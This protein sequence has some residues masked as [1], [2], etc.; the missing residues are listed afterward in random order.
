MGY[1]VNQ[2]DKETIPNISLEA[3]N[4]PMSSV[5]KKIEQASHYKIIF[6]YDEIRNYKVTIS[7]KNKPVEEIVRQVIASYPLAF[8]VKNIFITIYA[9]KPND[10]KTKIFGQVTDRTGEPLMGVTILTDN[11]GVGGISNIDGEFEIEIPEGKKVGN[12][13][14][15]FVGQKKI[16]VPYDGSRINVIMEDDTQQLDEMVVVGYGTQKKSSLTSSIETIKSDDLLRMPVANLNLAL[17][18]QVAGLSV[19][20]TTGDPTGRDPKVSIRGIVGDPL[21]VIDGVPRF[22][23]NTTDSETRLSDLNPDDI[24]SISVLKDGA[25]AAVYGA[26]A[27]RGVILVTTKRAKGDN[28]LHINYRGQYSLQKATRFPEFLN[29]YD[30]AK[31]YNKALDNSPDFGEKYFSDQDLELIRTNAAPNKFGNENLFDYLKDFGYLTTHS[32]SVNGGS[33]DVSYYISGGYANNVGLYSGVGRDRYNYSMK[34]DVNLLKGLSLSMDISGTRSDNKNTSYAT[35]DAAYNFAPTQILKYTDGRLA[36]LDG[37]NPLIAVQGLGGYVRNKSAINTINLTVKYAVPF[38]SGLSVYAKSV[39][40]NNSA[41]VKTFSSPVTL[42]KTNETTGAI[43][44]DAKTVYPKASISLTENEQNLDNKLLEAGLNYSKDFAQKHNIT[45]MLLANYQSTGSRY[46][47]AT[48]SSLSGLYPEIIGLGVTGTING[49]ESKTER[50]STVGRV[51]YGYDYRYF[52]EGNFRI[53]GSTKF[54]PDYRWQ[55]FPSFSGSWVASNEPF[56]KNWKQPVLSSLKFRASTGWLGDDAGIE[57]FSYQMKYIYTKN[58]GYSFGTGSSLFGII[59]SSEPFPNENLK[60]EQRHDYNLAT[61]LGFWD[62]RFSV[63]YEYYWRYRTNMITQVSPYLYPP[64]AGV[65]GRYPYVN[66]GEVKEWGWDLTLS[67][68]NTIGALKYNVDLMISK[69]DNVVL[70]WGDE[71]SLAEG[72]QRKGKAYMNWSLY[73]ADGLFRSW[74]EIENYDVDQD[75]SQN[76]TIQPGY[77]KYKDLNGDKKITDLDVA[78]VKNSSYPDYSFSV[79]TGVSYKGFFVNAVFQGIAGYKQQLNEIYSLYNSSLPKFQTYHR[80]DSWSE[81]NP[82]ASYPRVM[83]STVNSNNRKASTFW[84]KECD[85]IRLRSLNI[86]YGLP[87]KL[88]KGTLVSSVNISLQGSNLFT[89][90]TLDGID[91]ESL[92]G[93]P[94]QRGYGASVSVGF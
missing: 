17:I 27:A 64:S 47:S 55:I 87:A 21:L 92:R 51:T 49:I 18:G 81:D 57:N 76:A 56:F 11:V 10:N 69:M 3:K 36:S 24:E 89:W 20:Q 72:Q 73:Q 14:F 35:I 38:I 83:F 71:S 4:E 28:K 5:L 65:G 13:T 70:D 62:N 80:D 84:I 7:V 94:V 78:F 54:A 30:F 22:G 16:S 19:I 60:M 61:D 86:G 77:I 58:Y 91:P 90:S 59:P 42:Y 26:R 31:L 37:G 85:F 33:R 88:L 25:A 79:K 43:E 6:T 34:L 66:I 32:L 1:S 39:F 52:I 93:Y 45:A 82:N 15:S 46:L 9:T 50:A 63:T 2:S 41:H 23:T 40:D 8:K 12:V 75:K 74:E 48:N 53:D 68:R 44:E 67:H 29:A